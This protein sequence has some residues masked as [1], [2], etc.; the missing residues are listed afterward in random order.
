MWNNKTSTCLYK[1][2]ASSYN[3]EILSTFNPELHL[4]DTEFA[5]KNKLKKI[6][7]ELTGFKF[8]TTL[9][10]VFKKIEIDDKTKYYIFFHTQKQK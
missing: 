1:G 10:L 3:I 5:I 6:L 8:I 7:T 9:I 2:Y 4:R